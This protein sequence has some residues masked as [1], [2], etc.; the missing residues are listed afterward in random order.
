MRRLAFALPLLLA[1]S[2]ALAAP[3]EKKKG[4]GESFIQLPTLTATILRDDGR[5]GVLTVDIGLDIAD[6]GLRQRATQSIPLLIDAYTRQ[7]LIYAPSIPPG[8]PPNP[9]VISAELQRA[10]DQT[11]GRPGAK[12]LLGTI[13]EN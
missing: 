13:L 1:A 8:A 3:A 9:D 5:R 10:T 12:L 4:G 11:L 6:G 7:M 2:V